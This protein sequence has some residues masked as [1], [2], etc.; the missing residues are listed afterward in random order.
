MNAREETDMD[1]DDRL[2]SAMR[3]LAKVPTFSIGDEIAKWN[4]S[5][6]VSAIDQTIIAAEQLKWRIRSLMERKA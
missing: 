2:I 3:E 1:G 6:R 5:A 4:A